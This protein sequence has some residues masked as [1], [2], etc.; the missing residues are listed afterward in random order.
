LFDLPSR[1]RTAAASGGTNSGRLNL[2]GRAGANPP[3][4]ARGRGARR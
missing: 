3:G 4:R 2:R 1:R